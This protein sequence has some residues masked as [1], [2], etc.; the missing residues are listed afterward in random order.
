MTQATLSVYNGETLAFELE[1]TG[2]DG[3][4]VPDLTDAETEMRFSSEEPAVSGT[5]DP[6]T[7]VL[8]FEVQPS[9]TQYWPT[10]GLKFQVWLTYASGKTEMVVS[11]NIDVQEAF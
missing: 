7:G 4:P 6:A 3:N 10:A 2:N 8:A 5:V 1:Y 9:Q 11:G